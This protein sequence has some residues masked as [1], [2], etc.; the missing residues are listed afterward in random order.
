MKRVLLGLSFLLKFSGARDPVCIVETFSRIFL[1]AYME[2]ISQI[3][4]DGGLGGRSGRY[5]IWL[6]RVYKVRL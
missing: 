5:A 2:K 3:V 1:A 6:L 4:S